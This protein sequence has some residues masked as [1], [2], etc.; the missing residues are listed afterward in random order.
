MK[1]FNIQFEV[2]L[3]IFQHDVQVTVNQP[4]R[5]V[6]GRFGSLDETFTGTSEG[7]NLFIRIFYNNCNNFMILYYFK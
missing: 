2:Y 5:D 6:S 4:F 1:W 7:I 3:V